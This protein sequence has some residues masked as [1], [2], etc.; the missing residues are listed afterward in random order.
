MRENVL[1]LFCGLIFVL[2]LAGQAVAGNASLNNQ[3][4]SQDLQPLGLGAVSVLGSFAADVMENWQSKYL[5]LVPCIPAT[6]WWCN[7]VCPSRRSR[8]ARGG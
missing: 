2:A 4:L 1:G 8:A 7:P 5:K 3:Q 6:V